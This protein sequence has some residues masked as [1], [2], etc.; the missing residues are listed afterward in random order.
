MHKKKILSVS[1]VILGLSLV[2]GS[3]AWFTASDSALK[4]FKALNV[5]AEIVE[6]FDEENALK[7]VPG[8]TIKKDVDI[9]VDS[10]A[11]TFVR[12]KIEKGWKNV[13]DQSKDN[14]IQLNFSK[15]DE[16]SVVSEIIDEEKWFEQDG[17]LYY[18]GTVKKGDKLD[19]LDSVTFVPTKD[20]S[21]ADNIYQDKEMQVNVKLEAIQAKNNAFVTG[22]GIDEESELGV[23]LAD[24][25]KQIENIK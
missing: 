17:Y 4:N 10:V 5:K 21:D 8:D 14:N 18:I 6:D 2:G 16:T 9:K 24:L 13:S 25:S 1:A 11:E 3:L 12:V 7:I 19:L 23:K 20:S 15:E 22:W